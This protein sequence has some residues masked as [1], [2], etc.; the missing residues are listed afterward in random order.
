MTD[1]STHA[2]YQAIAAELDPPRAPF[3]DGKYRA[4]AWRRRWRRSTLP[5]V[6][7]LAR[8]R[9]V[10]P[11]MWI[12]PWPSA[13]AAFDQGHWAKMHPSDRKDVLIRLCKLITRNARELAVMESLDSGKPILDCETIDVPETMNTHQMARRGDRQDLRPN[14]PCG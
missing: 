6:T 12:L 5:R 7:D 4:G 11:R 9:A 14:R 13:R 1:L 10:A 3:I 8:L 2:E